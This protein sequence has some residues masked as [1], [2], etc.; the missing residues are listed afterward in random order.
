M[1]DDLKSELKALVAVSDLSRYADND[2]LLSH[3][4]RWAASEI[5]KR[6]GYAPKS[7]DQIVEDRYRYNVLQGA[8]DWLSR[9]GGEEYQ[10]FSENGVSGSYREIPS[11]LQSVIPKLGV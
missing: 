3:S 6:R 8:M 4:I 5:N 7:L 9:I 2:A 1:L 11:W 10:S